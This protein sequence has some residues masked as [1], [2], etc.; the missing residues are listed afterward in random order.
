VAADPGR[1]RWQARRRALWVVA[2]L[3]LAAVVA[4]TAVIQ[5]SP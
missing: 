2:A 4:V 3:L 1:W 5:L